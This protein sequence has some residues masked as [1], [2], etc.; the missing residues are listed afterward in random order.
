MY[1][2]L[3]FVT[4]QNFARFRHATRSFVK[5]WYASV[6]AGDKGL[7]SFS[8]SSVW[9]ANKMTLICV[10]GVQVPPSEPWGLIIDRQIFPLG[11][12]FGWQSG[13]PSMR[14]KEHFGGD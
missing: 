9:M 6:C 7:T 11:Y 5:S 3:Q 13:L 2:R 14:S 10:E 1:F 4:S 12:T 8:S